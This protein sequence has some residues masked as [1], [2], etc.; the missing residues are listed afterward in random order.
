MAIWFKIEAGATITQLN[1]Q[2]ESS[3]G[4]FTNLVSIAVPSNG[5]S[6]RTFASTVAATG[7]KVRFRF[8]GVVGTVYVRQL[9]VGEALVFPIGQWS[10]IASP[11]F[12]AGIV[13]ENVIAINGSII[14]R[15]IRRV[16]KEATIDLQYLEDSWVRASW[17]PFAEHAKRRSFWYLWDPDRPAD[18]AFAA[19]T[20]IDPPKNSNPV[21]LLAVTMPLKL[22]TD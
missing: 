16:E 2:Y 10:G 8:L 15:N 3:P 17:E 13:Q 22:I 5:I 18:V 21:P 14:G 9:T 6:W 19:A 20:S 11:K 12:V 1:V 4:V 7:R